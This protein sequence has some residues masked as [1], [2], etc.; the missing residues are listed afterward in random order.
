M[1]RSISPLL[2]TCAIALATLPAVSYAQSN[3][4][5]NV[6]AGATIP[7]GDLS[8]F[9][10]VGYNLTA[11]IGAKPR[12]SQLG[13]R[14]EGM[15]NELGISET[16]DKIRVAGLTANA[17]YDLPLSS[18]GTGNAFYVIGGIGY[19]NTKD[20]GFDVDE[21]NVG[22]NVGAGFRFPLTSFSAYVEAR[23]HSVSNSDILIPNVHMIPIVFG[24][25][26]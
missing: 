18:M 15:F 23:Y 9:T 4:H 2:A 17:T 12:A 1:I 3:I 8:N 11:G 22:F 19:Y 14:V 25:S 5:V 10:D 16:S 26:F 6:A 24:L 21:S 7:T 13:F 20:T